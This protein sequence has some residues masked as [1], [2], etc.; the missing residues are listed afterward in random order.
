[1]ESQ[2]KQEFLRSLLGF[3]TLDRQRK[4]YIRRRLEVRNT[5][6][7]NKDSHEIGKIVR[8]D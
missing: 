3:T 6:E 5:I 1:M 7:K 8:K 4:R 2:T